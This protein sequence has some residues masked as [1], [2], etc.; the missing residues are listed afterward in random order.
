MKKF[1]NYVLSVLNE[2]F[3]VGDG[4]IKRANIILNIKSKKY[5]HHIR[6]VSNKKSL[7]LVCDDRIW[8]FLHLCSILASFRAAMSQTGLNL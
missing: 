8:D 3:V 4:F 2:C 1:S 6:V 5:K 7:L